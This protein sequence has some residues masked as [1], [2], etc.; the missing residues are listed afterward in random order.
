MTGTLGSKNTREL[1]G[2]IY[3]LDFDYIPPSS[4]RIL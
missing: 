1:L 4:S 3:G 2:D